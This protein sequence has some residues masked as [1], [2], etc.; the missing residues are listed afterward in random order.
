MPSD[1]AAKPP[2][3]DV[4]RFADRVIRDGASAVFGL[5]VSLGDRLGIY[6]AMAGSGPMTVRQISEHCHLAERHVREW[7]AAQVAAEYV[8]YDPRSAAYTLP[9]AHAAVLSDPLSPAC[10]T[11]LFEMLQAL[12]RCEDRLTEAYRTGTGIDWNEYPEPLAA[13]SAKFLRP[14]YLASL[15]SEWIPALSGDV[16]AKLRRGAKV[17]DIGCGLGYATTIMAQAYP[18]SQYHG[19]DTHPASID[20]ARKLASDAGVSDRLEFT[21]AKA[22]EFDGSGYDLVT[23]FMALHTMGDPAA[24]ARQVRLALAP[25]ATFMVVEPAA[26]GKLEENIGPTGKAMLSLSAVAAVPNA[27]AQQGPYALG[28]HA[29]DQALREIVTK[30]GFSR[31]TKAAGSALHAVY[32][33]RP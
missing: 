4:E 32:E 5:T 9:D 28:T 21:V 8:E 29:G 19:F 30:A 12:Y 26:S 22:Q 14:R 20:A 2:A 25:Q 15:T 17:A 11:G 6:Q 24:A 31:F 7:L 18:R 13:G 23:C 3:D 1:N 16:E 33:A 10:L 27:M